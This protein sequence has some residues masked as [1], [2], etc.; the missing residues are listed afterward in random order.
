[1]AL[2]KKCEYA[3]RAMIE[4]ALHNN[5]GPVKVHQIA[6]SQRIPLRFLEIIL[7]QLRHAGFAESKRGNEGGYRLLRPA[8]EITVGEIIASVQGTPMLVLNFA[9]KDSTEVPVRGDHALRGLC[10][11]VNLAV[12]RIFNQTSIAELVRREMLH[13]EAAFSTYAI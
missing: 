11:S 12:D 7:N 5:D 13:C 6:E 2:S 1:M 4:L 8:E 10:D 9:D 3:L